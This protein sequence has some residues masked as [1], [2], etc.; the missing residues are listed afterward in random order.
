[1]KL[2]LSPLSICRTPIF[3]VNTNLEDS[4][5]LLKGYIEESSPAFYNIIKDYSFND[6]EGLSIKTRFTIWKYFNRARFRPTPY[7][8]FASFS[9]VPVLQKNAPANIIH[10][11]TTILHSFANWQEKE[12]INFDSKWLTHHSSLFIANSSIYECLDDIRY[13]NKKRGII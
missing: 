13:I 6:Y 5:D 2:T 3:S 1:M 7:G 4:W 10:T 9:I 8:S 11:K 12:H